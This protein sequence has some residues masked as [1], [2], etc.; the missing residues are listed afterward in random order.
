MNYKQVINI[1]YYYRDKII[2]KYVDVVL[3]INNYK[4]Q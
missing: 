3:I 1:I 4:L 2:N